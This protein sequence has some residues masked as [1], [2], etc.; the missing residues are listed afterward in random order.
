MS[1]KIKF[2]EIRIKIELCDEKKSVI[3]IM[4]NDHFEVFVLIQKV[5]MKQRN[6]R[7]GPAGCVKKLTN[8]SL[9]K[10]LVNHLRFHTK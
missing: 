6:I 8:F 7:A 4:W 3:T 2:Q 10:L 1:D 5:E 9:I